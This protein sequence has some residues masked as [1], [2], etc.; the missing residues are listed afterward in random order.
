MGSDL[1]PGLMFTARI[2]LMRNR[3]MASW[4]SRFH[5]PFQSRRLEM[6]HH[7]VGSVQNMTDIELR[8]YATWD[9]TPVRNEIKQ[10]AEEEG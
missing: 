9:S 10:I 8:P 6:V 5:T 4:A 3:K 7:A 1:I 2:S